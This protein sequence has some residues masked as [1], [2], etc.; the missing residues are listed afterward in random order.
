M[1]RSI[2]LRATSGPL[3]GRLWE[4]AEIL[5]VGRLEALEVVLDD[6]SVSRY[7]AEVRATDRGW[8]VRDLGST[9]GTRLNGVRLGNGQWPLRARDLLQFGEVTLV[10]EAAEEGPGPDEDSGVGESMEELAFDGNRS[11]RAGEQLL[12]LLRAGHHLV[13]IEREEDL[14]RS[15]LDDAVTVLD[16]QRGAIVLAE[17]PDDRLQ[18]R[19]LATGRGEPRAALAGRPAPRG[20]P[21]VSPSLGHRCR[22]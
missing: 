7:H 1:K 12:A 13:H 14:L 10:V 22:T 19:A 8:R 16:A 11:P 15:I 5:R 18:L 21:P 9:N 4:A 3:K 20:R 17:G 2:R 6:N